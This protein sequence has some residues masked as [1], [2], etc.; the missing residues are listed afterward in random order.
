M[1]SAALPCPGNSSTFLAPATSHTHS[2]CSF[3]SVTARLP[4]ADSPSLSR[5]RRIQVERLQTLPGAKVP[6][7]DP[8]IPVGGNE[9]IAIEVQAQGAQRLLGT[10]FEHR[11]PPTVTGPVGEGF[12]SR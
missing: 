5:S 9:A 10:Y 3:P 12:R 8:P 7:T 2:T 11:P 6:G 4:S 1:V